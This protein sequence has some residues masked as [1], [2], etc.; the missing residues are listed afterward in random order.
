MKK[1]LRA[2]LHEDQDP[3]EGY[4]AVGCLFIGLVLF[5]G[6]LSLFGWFIHLIQK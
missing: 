1:S 3:I 2:Q 6:A 4:K 5:M